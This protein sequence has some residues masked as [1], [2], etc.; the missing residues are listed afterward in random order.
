M[1]SRAEFVRCT[2]IYMRASRRDADLLALLSRGYIGVAAIKS[3]RGSAAA[4]AAHRGDVTLADCFGVAR[5]RELFVG[6]RVQQRAM[7]SH[8][9]ERC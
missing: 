6:E 4:A 7:L 9:A 1:H 3:E 5:E 2:Y 8:A